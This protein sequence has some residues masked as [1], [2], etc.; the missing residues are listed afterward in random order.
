MWGGVGDEG[1]GRGISVV[2]AE[3]G[4]EMGEGAKGGERK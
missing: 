1:D 2:G 3:M 4:E